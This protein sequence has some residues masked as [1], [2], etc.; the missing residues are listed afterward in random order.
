MS[1]INEL[2]RYQQQF[3]G[4]APLKEQVSNGAQIITKPIDKVENLVSNTVDSFI[5]EQKDEETKKSHKTAIRVVSTVLVLSAFIP[6]LNP[7]FS[8]K[9]I[10]KMKTASAKYG[11]K[12]KNADT[13]TGKLYRAAESTLYKGAKILNYANNFNSVKDEAFKWFCN[14][15]K[16]LKKPHEFITKGF[17][18][19]SKS[20]VLGKYSKVRTSVNTLNKVLDSYKSKLSDAER[21]K[22]EALLDQV[23]LQEKYFEKSSVEARLKAQEGVMSGLE[24]DTINKIK[25]YG[26]GFKGDNKIKHFKDNLYFWAED[27]IMPKRNQIEADGLKVINSLVG[28]GKTQ[29]GTYNEIIELISSHVGDN[30]KSFIDELLKNTSNKLHNANKSE[31]IE[32]FDKKRDLMLGSAPTDILT[33]LFGLGASGIA[34]GTADNKEDRVSRAV[35]VAFPAIAG[36]GVSMGMTAMLY[37]GIKGMLIGSAASG[38]LSITGST[39]DKTFIRKNKLVTKEGVQE[40]VKNV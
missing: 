13:F 1:N 19:I 20:T 8:S 5:P 32:Y 29:K 17:D 12:G 10:N 21:I 27:I 31:C 14:K 28:D 38:L 3:R 35:T 6:L 7:K 18:N 36:L 33:A 25:E 39:I 11:T 23:K 4:T 24:Q 22:L 26:R 37:S 15:V 16:F 30:E 2:H 34:I 40:E 9:L